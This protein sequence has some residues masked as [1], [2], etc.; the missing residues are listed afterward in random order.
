MTRRRDT[1]PESTRGKRD[2]AAPEA[3]LLARRS[4]ALVHTFAE[5]NIRFHVP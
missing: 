1:D 5:P 2:H 4:D 3:R